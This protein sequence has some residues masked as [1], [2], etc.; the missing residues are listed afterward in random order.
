LIIRSHKITKNHSTETKVIVNLKKETN[1]RFK[2]ELR[3]SWR[4]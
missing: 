3:R 4:W 1:N 2:R